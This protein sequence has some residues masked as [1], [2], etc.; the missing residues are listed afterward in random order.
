MS[1]ERKEAYL[2][3]SFGIEFDGVET[4]KF[5]RCEGLEAETYIYEVEEG[6]LNTT[7]H[8]FFGRTRYPVIV[9]ENGITDNND[10]WNWYKDTVLSEEEIERKDGSI[11]M[12][13]NEGTELKRWNFYKALPCRWVGPKLASN[14]D[15]VAI[16]RIEF[17]HEG[18]ELA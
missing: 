2:P 3:K 16:E 15:G 5:M 7:T 14:M 6:G 10:L 12:Y 9:L 13:D 1:D 18:L 8:K 17:V 11:V 4:A